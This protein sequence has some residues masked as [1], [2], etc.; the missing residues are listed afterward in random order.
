MMELN[1]FW[2]LI[3]ASRAAT[4]DPDERAEWLTDRLAVLPLREIEDFQVHLDQMRARVDTWTMWGAGYQIMNGLCSDDGFFYFQGWLVGLGRDNFER[5][6]AD[7]DALAEVPEIQRLAGRGTGDWAEDE[8]PDWEIVDYVAGEAHERRT[9]E[10]ESLDDALEAR[11]HESPSVP[12]PSGEGWS[13]GDP[14]EVARRLPRI[15]RM[16]P[17][18][19]RSGRSSSTG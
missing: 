6:A 14:H 3:E 2:T 15:G 5:V 13:P 19:A 10:E 7:P 16:F 11:G 1:G 17:S 8:W 18:G 4:N 12:D 9:G